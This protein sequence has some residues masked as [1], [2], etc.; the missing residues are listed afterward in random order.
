[1]EL[2]ENYPYHIIEKGQS[3]LLK[4]GSCQTGYFPYSEVNLTM[5][6][7]SLNS[8]LHILLIKKDLTD[9]K[10]L[11]WVGDLEAIKRMNINISDK[12]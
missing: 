10:V 12:Y 2:I 9:S 5:F 4:E 3:F 7:S 8:F 11:T 1:M 6:L